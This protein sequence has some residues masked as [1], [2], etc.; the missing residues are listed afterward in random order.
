MNAN[1]LLGKIREAQ[2]SQC[3]VAKRM[4]ISPSA[5]YHKIS[6]KSQFTRDEIIKLCDILA[7]DDAELMAI[8]FND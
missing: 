6:G 1:K 8:F 3:E 2:L 5:L 4:G 7:L